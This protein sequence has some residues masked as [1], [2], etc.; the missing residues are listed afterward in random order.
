M[1][2]TLL[3]SFYMIFAFIYTINYLSR[4]TNAVSKRT[5]RRE[6]AESVQLS[7]KGELT[8]LFFFNLYELNPNTF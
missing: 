8:C 3:S 1:D 2:T 4:L 6:I 5:G 7:R